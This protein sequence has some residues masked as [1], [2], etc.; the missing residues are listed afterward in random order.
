MAPKLEM[1]LN[2]ITFSLITSFRHSQGLSVVHFFFRG[3]I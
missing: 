3:K 1:H 2:E